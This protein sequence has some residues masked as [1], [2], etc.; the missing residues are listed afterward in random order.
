MKKRKRERERE[1]ERKREREI[2]RQR[3]R[4]R[5]DKKPVDRH[6]CVIVLAP[7]YAKKI[8]FLFEFRGKKQENT[9]FK[10]VHKLTKNCATLLCQNSRHIYVT[11]G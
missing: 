6:I 2:R 4:E 9:F 7:L 5:G 11:R 10:I 3:E 1:R 8:T